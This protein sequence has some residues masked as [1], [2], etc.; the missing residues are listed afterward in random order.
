VLSPAIGSI[1]VG[2]SNRGEFLERVW[3]FNS[4]NV[5]NQFF[6]L[7]DLLSGIFLRIGYSTKQ[8]IGSSTKEMK[9]DRHLFQ[10]SHY[11]FN[12]SQHDTSK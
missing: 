8:S 5:S 11:R 4:G 7:K 2:R 3:T 10:M 1:E 12:Y 6:S 9:I